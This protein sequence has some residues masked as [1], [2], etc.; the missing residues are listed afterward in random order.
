MVYPGLKL[1]WIRPKQAR[2]RAI[3]VLIVIGRKVQG[4][5]EINIV[6][7]LVS[8]KVHNTIEPCVQTLRLPRKIIS[9][10]LDYSIP[11][12]SSVVQNL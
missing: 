6:L 3:L 10:H 8:A 4:C 9:Q 5:C 7:S 1:P 12:L 11:S 2:Q